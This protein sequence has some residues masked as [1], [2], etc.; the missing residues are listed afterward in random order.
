MTLSQKQEN[1]KT[2]KALTLPLVCLLL[3]KMKRLYLTLQLLKA[4]GENPCIE[5][6]GIEKYANAK[7]GR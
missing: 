4:E 5:G 1:N 6:G 7:I 2:V 3:A